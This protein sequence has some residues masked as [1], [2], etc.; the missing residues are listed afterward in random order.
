[1]LIKWITAILFFFFIN[2]IVSIGGEFHQKW[3]QVLIDFGKCNTVFTIS[4]FGYMIIFD[5]FNVWITFLPEIVCSWIVFSFI[6]ALMR[7]SIYKC[8]IRK[9]PVTL[10][11]YLYEIAFLITFIA[12]AIPRIETYLS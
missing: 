6:L 8:L 1:M 11:L 2:F 4:N 9:E 7:Y 3:Y 12:T 10:K 5:K